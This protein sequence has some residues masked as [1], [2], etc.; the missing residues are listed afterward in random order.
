[1]T[2]NGIAVLGLGKVGELAATILADSGFD[3]TG[4]DL[5]LPTVGLPYKIL[6]YDFNSQGDLK[7]LLSSVDAVLSCLPYHL[8]VNIASAAHELGIHYFD[9]TEDVPTTRAI[10]EMSKT[11]IGLM[12]PQC[13]LAPGVRA[14]ITPPPNTA[15]QSMLRHSRI[16]WFTARRSAMA[17]AS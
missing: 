14:D 17:W 1:M 9:L 10:I 12:A 16:N 7:S 15:I 8:N 3:V 2:I 6:K 13:G 11:S 4:Y 5:R